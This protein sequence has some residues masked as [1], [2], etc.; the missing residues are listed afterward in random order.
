MATPKELGKIFK[1][2][3]EKKNITLEEASAGSRIHMNVVRD[4]ENGVLDRLGKPYVKSF[5]KKYAAFLAINEK[6]VIDIYDGIS[7]KQP[8]REF[9]LSQDSPENRDETIISMNSEKVQLAVVGVLA[10][11]FIVLIFVFVGMLK[12]RVYARKPVPAE[13]TIVV[14]AQGRQPENVT[15]PEKTVERQGRAGIALTL[16]ARGEVWVM[17]KSMDKT[18]YAATMQ[19]GDKKT[20]ESDSTLNLWT[21][22][23]ENL[24]MTV[25]GRALGEIAKGVVK[26]INISSSGVMIGDTVVTRLD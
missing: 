4:I 26:N 19:K 13:K 24:D 18:V 9:R 14:R 25:N 2:A 23:A 1:D 6:E 16:K 22:K 17:V 20:I 21:G 10:V 7:E 8:G 11:V 12:A 5:L 3:R 15:A